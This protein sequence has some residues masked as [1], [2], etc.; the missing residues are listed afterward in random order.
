MTV[1]M[2]EMGQET[3]DTVL[4]KKVYSPRVFRRSV[5]DILILDFWSPEP[6]ENKFLLF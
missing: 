4:D 6:W 3:S 5:A 1:S 2:Y